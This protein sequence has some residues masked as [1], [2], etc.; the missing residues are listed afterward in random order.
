VFIEGL[1]D[2][3]HRFSVALDAL[4]SR[5][6]TMK[7][8]GVMRVGEVGGN[9]LSIVVASLVTNRERMGGSTS[10]GGGGGGQ[11]TILKA[12]LDP[13]SRKGLMQVGHNIWE[14]TKIQSS[15]H[16]S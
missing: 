7:D 4:L 1:N 16:A 9:V 8:L 14:A 13:W 2:C 3:L 15:R 11:G 5:R 6:V 10:G 12:M